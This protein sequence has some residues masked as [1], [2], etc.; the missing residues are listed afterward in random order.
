MNTIS[1]YE[2]ASARFSSSATADYDAF[3]VTLRI[4]SIGL[5]STL[6]VEGVKPARQTKTPCTSCEIGSP[7]IYFRRTPFSAL[8]TLAFDKIF[9]ELLAV[10]TLDTFE[11]ETSFFI[12]DQT[13]ER[14]G[15]QEHT[16]STVPFRPPV[17]KP[18]VEEHCSPASFLQQRL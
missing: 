7:R 8:V 3:M 5:T 12:K 14:R 15:S 6:G 17:V 11:S 18:F 4:S 13:A 2:G 9:L 10:A 16:P 1:T